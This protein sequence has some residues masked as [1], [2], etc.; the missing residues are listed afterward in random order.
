MFRFCR[1]FSLSLLFVAS[2]LFAQSQ[3]ADRGKS[4]GDVARELRASKQSRASAGTTD[5]VVGATPAQP[6]AAVV[7][8]PPEIGEFT[9]SVALQTYRKDFAQLDKIADQARSTKARFPGGGWK[10]YT[11]YSQ[12][13]VVNGLASATESDWQQHLAFLQNWIS[14]RP[15]S[16]T[17]R[18]ALAAAYIDY[19]WQARG[20][21]TADQVTPE[22]WRLFQARIDQAANTLMEAAKLEAKCPQWYVEFEIVGRAKGLDQQQLREIFDKAVA[23]APDYYYVYQEEATSLLPKWG[24]KPGDTEA[25]AEESYRR[26]GGG[27]ESA[28][29]YFQ[30]ASQ[31]CNECGDFN[32]ERFSWPRLQEG[33]AVL[34]QCYGLSPFWL[35]KFARMAVVYEDKQ[36][37]AKAFARIGENWD[38]SVWGSREQFDAHRAWAGLAP[39]PRPADKPAFALDPDTTQ[40]LSSLLSRA[41]QASAEGHWDDAA[42]DLR[43][44]ITTAKPFPDTDYWLVKAYGMLAVNEQRQGHLAQAQSI[45]DEEVSLMSRRSGAN[46]T[47]FATAL[48]GRALL[49]QRMND[50]GRAETDFRRALAIHKKADSSSVQIPMEAYALAMLY[51]RHNRYKQAIDLLQS[52]IPPKANA[53]PQKEA[54]LG[55][56]LEALGMTYQDMGRYQDAEAAYA[57]MLPILEVTLPVN[58]LGFVDPLS[59]M[60]SLYHAMGKETDAQKIEKRLQELQQS[61]PQPH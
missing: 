28:L 30:I 23:F 19:A 52:L 15:K 8:P 13:R 1:Y 6:E 44:I 31:L 27:Q 39:A 11:F 53:D 56:L 50:D 51:R 17:A 43:R 24:G 25:F 35:N 18:V 5:R 7:A 2:A 47:D 34:E 36:A 20:N 38:E 26:L 61:Q 33:F 32:P 21:G 60:A 12:L 4:L 10:L 42:Q 14:A 40:Q 45:M 46:S 9:Q 41:T 54:N 22:G 37:A 59:K 16:I 58:S 57:R 29:L 49:E 48:F 55:W 3:G